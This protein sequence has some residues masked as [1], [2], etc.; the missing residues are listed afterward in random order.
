MT[1]PNA[2]R[3]AILDWMMPGRDGVDICREIRQTDQGLYTYIL[4]LTARSGREDLVEGLNAGADDYITKPFHEE[5]L[6]ARLR[7]A[8]RILDL[9][10]KLL[11]AQASLQQQATHDMLT[12][13]PNRF[14][15]S[16]RLSHMLV[17]ARRYH[18]MISVMFLDLDH[19]K[20]IND[21]MGHSCGDMLLQQVSKR[22]TKIL[23]EM[24]TVCR[25]G[26]DEFTIMLS[27]INAPRDAAL[28]AKKIIQE[29]ERPFELEDKQVNVSTSIGISLFPSDGADVETLLKL[30]DIAMYRAKEKG[31]NCYQFYCEAL[32]TAA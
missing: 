23:R 11:S 6:N 30:A 12:G 1:A 21:T 8:N 13:L 5:E 15:F 17:E 2:P 4:L 10:E 16:E 26:G 27:H 22:L 24:D 25:M 3:L 20:Q 9:Q 29:F 32:N 7:A 14:L 18:Q 28:I 31:R 19:F